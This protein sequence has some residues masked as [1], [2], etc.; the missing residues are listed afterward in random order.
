[1]Q[2]GLQG[3]DDHRT[4]IVVVIKL[5]FVGSFIGH[6]IFIHVASTVKLMIKTEH[7]FNHGIGAQYII[8][9][10]LFMAI[11]QC[12]LFGNGGAGKRAVLSQLIF[13]FVLILLQF[14]NH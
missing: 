7:A 3:V 6:R 14:L 11:L 9:H 8:F 4:D 13:D 2:I 1:M 5:L 12:F 10:R